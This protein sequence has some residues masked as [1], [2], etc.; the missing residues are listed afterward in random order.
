MRSSDYTDLSDIFAL[1]D[2]TTRTDILGRAIPKGTVLDP[3][4]HALCRRRCSRPGI[5][6]GQQHGAAVMFATRSVRL[7]TQAHND[8]PGRLP[9]SEPASRQVASIRTPSRS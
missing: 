6:P 1:N 8:Y 9:R 2:G 5:R 4:H 3:G 7:R